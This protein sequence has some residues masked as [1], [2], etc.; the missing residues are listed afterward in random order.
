MRQSRRNKLGFVACVAAL[1]LGGCSHRA[2]EA[3]AKEEGVETPYSQ[4]K[5]DGF[6]SIR[7]EGPLSF[8]EPVRADVTRELHAFRVQSFGGTSISVDLTAEYGDPY[9]AIEGPLAGNGDSIVPGEGAVFATNDDSG[10]SY[11]S[12]LDVVLEQPGVYR[13]IAGTYRTL[14][15]GKSAHET[16][17][18]L[19]ASCTG[20]CTRPEINLQTLLTQLRDSGKLEPFVAQARAQ[21]TQLV[22]DASAQALLNGELDRIM[23]SPTFSGLERFPTLPLRQF[24]AFRLA[25]AGFNSA[26][27][28]PDQVVNGSLSDLLGG[29]QADRANPPDV[30]AALPGIG[31]GHF[32]DLTLSACQAAHSASLAQLLTSLS[33]GNGSSVTYE[34][35]EITTPGDLLRALMRTGHTVE[36]RNERSYANFLSITAGDINVRWPGW[37]DTGVVLDNGENLVVPMGH[38]QVTWHI[39]GPVVDARV[40]F[41][42]GTSGAAFFGQTSVRPAWTGL[43]AKDVTSNASS[44]TQGGVDEHAI[45]MADASALYLRRSRTERATVAQG[46][47]ADGY[48]YVGVCNDS[49]AAVEYL[50]DG[51]ITGFPLVRARALDDAER[52]ND[53]LDDVLRILP[54]DADVPAETRDALTRVLLMTPHPLDSTLL[55]DDALRAQ[56]V[57]AQAM[58]NDGAQ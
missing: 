44:V 8:G 43:S 1:A 11:N 25:L 7:D 13:V 15:L 6:F 58:L 31:N 37:L 34:G 32:P 28:A 56:L 55:V 19:S 16:E 29:C 2:L 21:I 50:V 20:A 46:M 26:A 23:A 39:R 12:H 41:Y 10:N 51:T 4:G 57:R 53:G 9:L 30:N 27:P 48:G 49:V 40:M 54:H 24:D 3:E 5:A 47:P 22:P 36:V 52:L 35:Q 17:L 18:Q 38:S 14:G 33:V 42:L 45:A